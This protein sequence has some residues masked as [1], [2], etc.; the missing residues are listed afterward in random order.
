ML[1]IAALHHIADALQFCPEGFHGE[2]RADGAVDIPPDERTDGG[3]SGL[4][5]IPFRI[6]SA[7]GVCLDDG[8]TMRGADLV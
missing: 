7:A 2:C 6:V 5:S 1:S 4:L 3:L 8:K